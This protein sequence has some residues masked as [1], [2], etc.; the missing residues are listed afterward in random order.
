MYQMTP[1]QPPKPP[2]KKLSLVQVLLL[3]GAFGFCAWYLYGVFAPAAA[4]TAVIGAGT[5]GARYSG[6]CLIVRDETPY[7]AEGVTS[8]DYEA[9]EGSV[10]QRDAKICYVYSSGFSTKEMTTLQDYRNQIRDYQQKLIAAETTYDAKMTRV[11]SDVLSRAREV[12]EMIAGARGSL[13][14]QEKLLS[15]AADRA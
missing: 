9:A 2:R 12:R 1:P 10:V 4:T 7:D 11:E 13:T 8:V 14:N 15:A 3:L 6:D 5:L